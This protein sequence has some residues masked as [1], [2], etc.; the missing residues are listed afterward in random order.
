MKLRTVLLCLVALVF[1]GACSHSNDAAPVTSLGKVQL[2]SPLAGSSIEVLDVRGQHLMNGEET[3]DAAGTFA[4]KLPTGGATRFRLVVTGGTY[5]GKPFQD[6]LLL[7][8]ER[9]DRVPNTLYVN[10]ATT[11]VSRYLDR[12]PGTGLA[13]AEAKV[14]AFLLIPSTSRVGADVANPLQNY[15]RHELLFAGMQSSGIAKLDTYLGKLIDEM[16]AGVISHAFSRPKTALVGS[17]VD[18]VKYLLKFLAKAL[19]DDTVSLVFEKITTAL[20]LDGTAEILKELHEI[21]HKLDE[22]KELTT[23]VLNAVNQGNMQ[24]L[25]AELNGEVSAIQGHYSFMALVAERSTFA[26]LLNA[27]GD[28]LDAKCAEDHRKKMDGMKT[29]INKT[30]AAI[31]SR[32]KNGVEYAIKHIHDSLLAGG[33]P[34]VLGAARVYVKGAMPF[35]PPVV[36]PQIVQINEYYKTIQAMGVHLLVEAYRASDPNE[37]SRSAA[38]SG[39]QDALNSFDR[40][41]QLQDEAVAKL[42]RENEDTVEDVRTKLIWLRAPVSNIPESDYHTW[43]DENRHW[44]YREG[45]L[46]QCDNLANKSYAGYSGWRLPTDPELH[47]VVKGGSSNGGNAGGKPGIFAWLIQQGFQAGPGNGQPYQRGFLTSPGTAYFSKTCSGDCGWFTGYYSEALWDT[48]VDFAC[49][50]T[51]GCG[52]PEHLSSAVGAWCVTEGKPE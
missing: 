11:L 17:E 48:G 15:F 5:E 4:L 12:H 6:R 21:N 31:L 33:G 23:E 37:Y 2:S 18:P 16:D 22:L 19:G 38:K 29:D 52:Y 40:F 28:P 50:K 51:K 14:K 39:A 32:D 35:D 41:A 3:T 34:G 43:W 9:N 7:D 13:D 20:G 47:E 30:I 27:K 44:T 1:V 25:M 8:F 26:C 49:D 10:A 24:T 46:Q 42:R 45:A 36:N